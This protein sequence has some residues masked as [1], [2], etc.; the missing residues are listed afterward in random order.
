[1]RLDAVG[2]SAQTRAAFGRGA[3]HAVVLDLDH[4]HPVV[5]QGAN[6]RLR[7]LRVLDHV[8]ESLA[9]DEIRRRFDVG[10]EALLGRSDRHGKRNPRGQRLECRCETPLR[11]DSRMNS[12]RKLTQLLE[13]DLE[14]VRSRLQQLVDLG[15]AL[16]AESPLRAS[17]LERQRNEPLLGAVV[18]VAL[19]PA[20]LL[21][22]GGDDPC[23][24][25][26]DHLE[27]SPHLR[28]QPRVDKGEP[29][30]GC[31]MSAISMPIAEYGHDEGNCSV[32]GGYVY[33]GT[34]RPVLAGVY[35]F[36]D[37]CSG[38]IWGL[39]SGGPMDQEPVVLKETARVISSF[40]QDDAGELYLTDLDSGDIYRV[41][42]RPVG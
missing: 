31:D 26:L 2:Q 5:A 21:V 19:D 34:A 10:R 24:R 9:G 11:E 27:L 25:L 15:I 33:R 13:G 16:L 20:P 6:R 32:V 42:G 38:T 18:E 8:R 30:R 37:T 28:V 41:V 3:A 40:G 1:M 35:V 29:S 14:L 39:A 22:G 23:A 36:G 7:C 17:E 4:E 12:L